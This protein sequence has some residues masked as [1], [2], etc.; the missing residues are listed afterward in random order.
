MEKAMRESLLE[1]KLQKTIKENEELR[2]QL[3][4][5]RSKK[6]HT[7]NCIRN[8]VDDINRMLDK[9]TKF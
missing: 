8:Y 4:L 5:Q 7:V 3:T 9:A 1:E 6:D 2:L